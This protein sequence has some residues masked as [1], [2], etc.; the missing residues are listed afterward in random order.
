MNYM[1]IYLCYVHL[2]L[3]WTE[4][5]WSEVTCYIQLYIQLLFIG[6]VVCSHLT[7]ND[8]ELLTYS[9]LSGIKINTSVTS[10]I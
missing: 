5:A 7:M 9:R 3:C 1:M 10:E 6:C 4:G 8:L 2:T